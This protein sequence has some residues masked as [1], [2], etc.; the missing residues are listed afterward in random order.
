MAQGMEKNGDSGEAL[1]GI[2]NIGDDTSWFRDTPHYWASASLPFAHGLACVEVVSENSEK[3]GVVYD[4]II[5]AWSAPGMKVVFDDIGS[6]I[7]EWGKGKIKDGLLHPET[8]F[9]PDP[10]RPFRQVDKAF[11]GLKI[12]EDFSKGDDVQRAS[13]EERQHAKQ[14]ADLAG[15]IMEFIRVGFNRESDIEKGRYRVEVSEKAPWLVWAVGIRTLFESYRIRFEQVRDFYKVR[16][17]KGKIIDFHK[18]LSEQ[19]MSRW[20]RRIVASAKAADLRLKNDKTIM[21][22]ARRW[23]ECRVVYPSIKK[24]C[25]AKSSEGI[26][27]EVQNVDKQI[28]PCDDAVGYIRRLPRKT[29]K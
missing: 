13:L 7:P 26:I 20:H 2:R 1:K 24:F 12:N 8:G 17:Y 15:R 9:S 27:L 11:T 16:K 25:D 21:E 5:E 22:A 28:E 14:L 23:Y 4:G 29:S 18:V 10:N 6:M 3:A 19:S